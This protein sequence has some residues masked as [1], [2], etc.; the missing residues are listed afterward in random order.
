MGLAQTQQLL[1]RLYTDTPLRERFFAD[2]RQVGAELGLT[3]ADVQQM[4]ALS[5]QEV[6]FFAASLQSKRRNEVG[7]LLPLTSRALGDRF[8]ALFRHYADAH[9]PQGLKKHRDDAVEF[10]AFLSEVINAPHVAP[11]IRDLAS[12]EASWLR[13]EEPTRRWMLRRFRYNV[14]ELVH[15]TGDELAATPCPQPTLALWFRLWP[16]RSLHHIILR[17]PRLRHHGESP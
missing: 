5:E 17:L 3:S 6:N 8:A 14:G 12:Y 13:A 10:A 15:R 2:P 1:A 4:L 11:W 16:R 7:K 9:V